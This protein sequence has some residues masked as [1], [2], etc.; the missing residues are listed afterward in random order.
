MTWEDLQI[1]IPRGKTTGQVYTICPKCSHDRRKKNTKC[2]GVNL[3]LGVYHCNH[4]DWKGSINKKQYVQPKWE[5]KTDLSD[6]VVEWF[7]SRNISS[8][9]I[10]AMKVTEAN[11]WMPQKEANVRAICFNYFRDGHLVNVKYRDR[12]KNFR[13]VKDAEKIFYNLDGI[14]D[15]NEIWIVE[16]EIDCLTMI[17]AGITNCVSVPNGATKGTNN[18]DYLDNC[19]KYFENAEKVYIA[20][21]QDEPGQ[22]LADELARRIGVIFLFDSA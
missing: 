7:Q 11:V 15:Q 18:L 10:R 9:T 19:F 13:M 22:H 17:Q 4:C 12:E 16:G 20:T 3:D 14:K 1:D 2:L 21:D 5:N 6:A 8:D